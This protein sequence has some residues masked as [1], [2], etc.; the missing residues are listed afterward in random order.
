MTDQQQDLEYPSQ[1]GEIC[2]LL[3]PDGD[4][5]SRLRACAEVWRDT[6]R[7]LEGTIE[8]QGREVAR[9]GDNWRGPAADAFHAHWNHTRHQVTEALPQ[10]EAVAEQLEA[11]ADAVAAHAV[12]A[13]VAEA[14]DGAAR[15][16][17]LLIRVAAA[18]E[19]A[20]EAMS[21]SELPA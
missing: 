7:S 15:L 1:A 4:R 14:A 13:D 19:T 8:A 12:A 10:F 3:S 5:S 11:A 16:G 18:L 2:D 6:A 20:R 9:L 17:Q 21:K